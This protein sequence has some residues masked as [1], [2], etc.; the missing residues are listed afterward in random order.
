MELF[1]AKRSP[2]QKLYVHMFKKKNRIPCS[3]R[4]PL[5][6]RTKHSA[7]LWYPDFKK[8]PV[9]LLQTL[10]LLCNWTEK[11]P[12]VSYSFFILKPSPNTY[13]KVEV[14][15]KNLFFLSSFLKLAGFP[16]RR[17][18]AVGDPTTS[19]RWPWTCQGEPG[20]RPSTWARF[21][22]GSRRVSG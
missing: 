15:R 18:S 19:W 22:R 21:C 20:R 12:F 17:A 5:R 1:T 16:C 9:L 8:E 3:I 11:G 14:Q 2:G 4:R 6:L 10:V 7:F 13:C